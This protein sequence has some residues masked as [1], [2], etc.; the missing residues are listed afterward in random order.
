LDVEGF[1]HLARDHHLAALPH[2]SDPLW[3]LWSSS[4]PNFQINRW[5]E[6]VKAMRS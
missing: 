2:A 1:E 3:L 6:T 5:T 4:L